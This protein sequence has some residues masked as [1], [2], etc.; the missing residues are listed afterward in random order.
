MRCVRQ[1]EHM[2][3]ACCRTKRRNGDK[4]MGWLSERYSRPGPG[5]NKDEP[6]KKGLALFFNILWRELFELLKLNLLFVVFCIPIITIPAALTGVHRVL[7]MMVR[8]EPVFLWR[9]FIKSFRREFLRSTL[10]GWALALALFASFFG[11]QFYYQMAQNMMFMYLPLALVG[12]V[13]ITLLFMGFYLFPL[14]ALVELPLKQLIRNTF[15]LACLRM[16]YNLSAL[17]VNGILGFLLVLF[18]PLSITI[19]FLIIFSLMGLVSTFCAYSG[20]ERFVLRG[21]AE[22]A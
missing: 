21:G 4:C 18:F 1:A 10:L 11:V 5:I 2:C 14:L 15:L 6:K 13:G 19:C 3:A 8:D 22:E 17:A 20:I 16:P 9:E 7:V 12:A